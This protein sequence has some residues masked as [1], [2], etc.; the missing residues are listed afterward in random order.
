[1]VGKTKF[2]GNRNGR[3]LDNS[4][5]RRQKGGNKTKAYV[6]NLDERTDRWEQIQNDFKDTDIELERVS[7]IKNDNGHYGIAKSIQKIVQMAKDTNLEYVTIF[8][9]DNMPTENF[10]SNWSTI[11]NW[12]DTDTVWEIFNG[13]P[14]I[15]TKFEG[16]IYKTLNSSI[17]LYK[18]NTVF[19]LNFICINRKAYDKILNY[20]SESIL[21][22]SVVDSAID[23]FIGSKNNF[24]NIVCYPFLSLQKSGNSNIQGKYVNFKDDDNAQKEKF[25]DFIKSLQVGGQTCN[26]SYFTVST[27]DTP[28]L[29][30][31]KKSAEKF[32]WKLD[33]LGLEEN[34]DQLGWEDKSNRS[35]DYGN[36]SIKLVKELEYVSNKSPDDIVLF[37]DAWDVVCLG[38][39]SSLYEKFLTFNKDL[40][41]G[42]EKICSPDQDK[43]DLYKIKNVPFPYL[44]SGFFIGKAGVIKNYLDKYNGEKINDQKWWTATYLENQDTIALDSNALM[45]LQTWDTDQKYYQFQDNKFTYTETS[46]NPN[47]IHANGHIKDKLNLFTP[48][49]QNGGNRQKVYVMNL[50]DRPEKWEEI[51]KE[52]NT[53][54]DL[55]RFDAIKDEVGHRGCGKSFQAL[56]KMAKDENMETI[57]IMEDDCKPLENFEE[58]WYKI[59]DWLDSNK[60]KWEVFNGGL[61]IVSGAT[62][63]L[64]DTLDN[65]DKILSIDK[66]VNCH[67]IL[68]KNDAYDKILEWDWDKN[69]LI[70]FN[71]IN[72]SKFKTLFVEPYLTVQKDGYSDTEKVVKNNQFGGKR[73]TKKKKK[74][75]L[76]RSKKKLKGGQAQIIHYVVVSTK[77]TPELHRLL[78]SGKKFGWDIDVLGLEMNTDEFKHT[79]IH[80]RNFEIKLYLIKD[81]LKKL[82][83]NDL[84]LLSDAWDV[85][86]IGTKE[87]VLEKYKKFNMPIV[88][89]AEKMCW[90][91]KDRA[92]QYNTLQEAFPYLNS[93]GYIGTV[94]ALKTVFENYNN[95]KIV[96]DQRFW[97]DMYFK[98]KDLIVLDTKAEIFISLMKTDVNNYKFENSV[99]TYKET[100]TNPLIIHG[101]GWQKDKL[102]LFTPL[103]QNGGN[104]QK[105]YVINL[106]ERTD[107]WNKI[108]ET[109]KN[110][111]FN[112]ERISAVKNS[113]RN[114]G[115]GLS[116]LDIIKNAKN[117]NESTVLIF[118]D[119]NKPL[120]NFDTN[121]NIIKNYL[122]SSMNSWDIFNGG[123]R[124]KDWGSY[125]NSTVESKYSN[126][127]EL[128]ITLDNNINICKPK[129]PSI[130]LATNWIYINS[131]AYDRIINW[132][133]KI[134]GAID[135]FFHNTN[136]FK[137]L[138][139]IPLL[140]L[141]HLPTNA[142]SSTGMYNASYYNFDYYDPIIIK[143]FDNA[144]AKLKQPI[145]G[146]IKAGSEE[147]KEKIP[148]TKKKKNSKLNRSKKK[149]KG[150]QID[151]Q[152]AYVINLDERTDR[153]NK[154]QETF[155]NR[156]FN[157]ERISAVKN[158]IGLIGC[159]ISFVKAV[160][161]AKENNLPYI[162]I[163]EDDCK[164][165]DNFDTLWPTIKDW[166]EK[167]MD[168]WEIFIGGNTAY[169]F[170]DASTVKPLCKIDENVKLYYTIM[171]T[172]N[173]FCINSSV[174][175]KYIDVKQYLTKELFQGEVHTSD[176]WPNTQKMKIVTPV[177]FIAIQEPS[178]SDT[179]GKDENYTSM[180]DKSERLIS[181]IEN[182]ICKLY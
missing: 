178:H 120:E 160:E 140:G 69:W 14:R 88:V 31:L 37:T 172:A 110:G 127:I 137:V 174:Y 108:Q 159:T 78:N 111:P 124:F 156:P 9:D 63:N 166:L 22:K 76:N 138:F 15:D 170:N 71:Y 79:N 171:S 142:N 98:Y 75:K 149:L 61:K 151:K 13:S 155:K 139:S 102:N 91:D 115:C 121:W 134:D 150:G 119:D 52:F 132:D 34:T 82:N 28:E 30:R 100:G 50:K 58:R 81:Y 57:L 94:K 125:T 133:I 116:F 66:G 45:C 107:R 128:V 103:L 67:M 112:L 95:E 11:K 99:F 60:D 130:L 118:E 96:D 77:D 175:D 173:F 23:R 136:I 113:D 24:V 161:K 169:A 181:S 36:F 104:R 158:E 40:V 54:F 2:G 126:S 4:R 163:M 17:S 154:I 83:D 49:L 47:F 41:F 64:V 147:L 164:P 6:V 87:Q 32:G 7:A 27:K 42:A 62:T 92:S 3:G 122:D 74:S 180:F 18:M 182:S 38:D 5:K 162:L 144:I 109:F 129:D 177:P 59:K 35:G 10:N 157:L 145:G 101:N 179:T 97:T 152:K 33:I 8:E 135:V 19:A 90:P 1:M 146:R 16:E 168:K 12:L 72:T 141:Q 117:N 165:K 65:A 176:K 39:C 46:T 55:E 85:L 105:A 29:Q 68:V 53:I 21:T 93:G 20:D 73:R 167:N 123:A 131:S 26:I 80:N 143:L 86:V 51:Q 106:D 84:L 148:R 89:S 70:D 153:W 114:L 25:E 43:K 48:L 56:V 44:N